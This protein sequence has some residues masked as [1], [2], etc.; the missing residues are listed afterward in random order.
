MDL[1]R[2]W[3][4]VYQWRRARVGGQKRAARQP[5]DGKL[6]VAGVPKAGRCCAR[7]D[8]HIYGGGVMDEPIVIRTKK[9]KS[10]E[11]VSESWTYEKMLD[12]FPD[13]DESLVN[14]LV[15]RCQQLEAEVE[16]LREALLSEQCKSADNDARLRDLNSENC[17]LQKIVDDHNK[18]GHC[19][20][21]G[22]RL[23][24]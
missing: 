12:I 1:R 23:F 18:P 19:R 3:L 13:G 6:L 15:R 8:E 17:R 2:V 24:L 21:C 16:W 7:D 22:S 5:L 14:P 9:A 4:S 10:Y 20:Y 11:T